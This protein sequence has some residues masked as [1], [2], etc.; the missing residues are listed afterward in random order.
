MLLSQTKENPGGRQVCLSSE[1]R[2]G[3]GKAGISAAPDSPISPTFPQ[4]C[5]W[6]QHAAVTFPEEPLENPEE[7]LWKK[8]HFYY[9]FSQKIPFLRSCYV[10][11]AL[12]AAEA[13]IPPGSKARASPRYFLSFRPFYQPSWNETLNPCSNPVSCY[14]GNSI[15]FIFLGLSQ[16]TFQFQATA[17]ADTRCRFLISSR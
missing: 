12:A 9:F 10:C 11:N 13:K 5:D 4:D 7:E 8:S 6:D 1:N 16:G 17:Q 3:G 2:E 14:L 15:T